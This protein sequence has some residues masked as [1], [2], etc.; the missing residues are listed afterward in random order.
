MYKVCVYLYAEPLPLRRRHA[1][2]VTPRQPLP[3]PLHAPRRAPLPLLLAPAAA[4]LVE[5]A[6]GLGRRGGGG[7]G[8]G[9]RVGGG[10]G[11]GGGGG[12]GGGGRASRCLRVDTGLAMNVLACWRVCARARVRAWV[13]C[14]RA[15]HAG[16]LDDFTILGR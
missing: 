9:V 16:L 8:V 7:V 11:G 1:E 14:V 12:V 4:G 10:G 15:R 13:R 2:A 6:G 5:G 3:G